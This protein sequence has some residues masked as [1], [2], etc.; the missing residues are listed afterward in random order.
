MTEALVTAILA[1]LVVISLGFAT[2]AA[3]IGGLGVLTGA[4]FERCPLCHHHGLVNGA[5]LHEQGCP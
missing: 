1:V 4:R 3:V 5:R 2:W